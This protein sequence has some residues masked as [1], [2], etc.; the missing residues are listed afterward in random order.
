MKRTKVENTLAAI[1]LRAKTGRAIA[2]LLAAPVT[3]PRVLRRLELKLH[4]ASL[5]DTAQPYHTVMHLPWAEAEIAVQ[6]LINA[7]ETVAA[8]SLKDFIS[9]LE[10]VLVCGIG[11][12]GSLDR[13][14]EKLG[15]YH[16]RAHAAEGILFRRVLETA[17][18][19]NHLPCKTIAEKE[20]FEAAARALRQPVAEVR[21]LIGEAR[22]ADLQPWRADE[23][24]AMAAAWLALASY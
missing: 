1:G 19:T 17:A 6:P 24:A 10:D 22:R 2:V 18:K 9:Q 8:K 7:I 15:N 5:P 4:D 14:L 13:N 11:V 21:R 23:K 3:G 16:I 12:V 20:V